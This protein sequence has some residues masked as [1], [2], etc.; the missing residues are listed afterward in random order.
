MAFYKKRFPKMT[1]NIYRESHEWGDASRP[2]QTAFDALSGT[3]LLQ[4]DRRR[5]E[6]GDRAIKGCQMSQWLPGGLADVQTCVGVDSDAGKD[7]LR[8]NELERSHSKHDNWE[9]RWKGWKA[10]CGK[11]GKGGKDGKAVAGTDGKGGGG[12]AL[13]CGVHGQEC[14]LADLS[15]A[16]ATELS[17]ERGVSPH[18]GDMI[19]LRLE[20]DRKWAAARAAERAAP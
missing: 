1:C 13:G 8:V 6:H 7:L 20:Q 14:G 3:E 11:G 5:R 4:Y 17:E 9:K 2:R 16:H 18:L 12:C 19:Q 10:K 15:E